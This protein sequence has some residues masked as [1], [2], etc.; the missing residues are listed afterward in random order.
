MMRDPASRPAIPGSTVPVP[1]PPAPPPAQSSATGAPP[2][3]PVPDRSAVAEK[4]AA[5]P[6]AAP[7]LVPPE[8]LEA[9][10]SDAVD[11]LISASPTA[12]IMDTAEALWSRRK[13]ALPSSR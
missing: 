10:A 3:A 12:S 11:L 13:A 7:K 1:S 8:T 4:P 9:A 2:A 6:S 5:L